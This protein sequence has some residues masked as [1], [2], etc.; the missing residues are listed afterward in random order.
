MRI[1]I[2]VLEQC[3]GEWEIKIERTGE[4]GARGRVGRS[5]SR[6]PRPPRGSGPRVGS[7][8]GGVDDSRLESGECVKVEN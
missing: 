5:R 4:I 1:E 2:I 3:Q 7:A 6:A 8:H